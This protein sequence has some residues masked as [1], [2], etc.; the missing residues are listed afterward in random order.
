MIK[1]IIT[2]LFII[3]TICSG[4]SDLS[5]DR[6]P[7]TSV[8][9]EVTLAQQQKSE[10]WANVPATFVTFLKPNIPYGFPYTISATTGYGGVLQVCGFD[11][12]LFAYD[13]SCPFEHNP[14]IRI[15]IDDITLNAVCREC[16]STYDVF[17]GSGAPIDGPSAA[18]GYALRKYNITY[19]SS[20]GSYMIIN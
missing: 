15:A 5:N 3:L 17:Y 12:E 6:I 14:N 9:I 13:L 11:N 19:I 1:K 18:N 7:L 4:C 10:Y 2:L 20:T 16:G 8:R